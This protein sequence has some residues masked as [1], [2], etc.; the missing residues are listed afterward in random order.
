MTHSTMLVCRN[1]SVAADIRAVLPVDTMVIG[2]ALTGNRWE[3]IIIPAGLIQP[4]GSDNIDGA[5]TDWVDRLS[6]K[7]T[8]GGHLIWL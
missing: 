5:V 1:A 2:D 7:L 8:Q 4:S 3:T 6:T